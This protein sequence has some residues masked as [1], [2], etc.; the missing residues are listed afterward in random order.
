MSKKKNKLKKKPRIV[1]LEIRQADI[2]GSLVSIEAVVGNRLK[3]RKQGSKKHCRCPWSK[4]RKGAKVIPGRIK[5]ITLC[6]SSC[7]SGLY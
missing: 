6:G 7:I 1:R 3:G 5:I 4:G 2:T